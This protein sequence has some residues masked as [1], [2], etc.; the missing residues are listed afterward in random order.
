MVATWPGSASS[1]FE[2][3]DCV[4]GDCWVD[5][6]EVPFAIIETRVSLLN[7]PVNYAITSACENT[8]DAAR[9]RKAYRNISEGSNFGR[10]D[11]L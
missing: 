11:L 5:P 1:R 2:L 8:M 6:I 9:S 4:W 10:Y 3:Q 7:G